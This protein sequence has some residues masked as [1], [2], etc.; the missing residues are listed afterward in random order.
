[1][2]PT[3]RRL[4]AELVRRKI[5]RSREQAVD[6][7]KAGR[8]YVGGFQAQKPATVVEPE[9]SIRV[10]EAADEDWASRG[11]HKLLGALDAFEPQGL[12]VA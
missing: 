11:A 2:A 7:I 5:A 8:V 9:V 4:D 3:R 12:S 6:M 10:E 1:M